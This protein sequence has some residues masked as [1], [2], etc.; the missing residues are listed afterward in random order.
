MWPFLSC[1]LPLVTGV[2]ISYTHSLNLYFVYILIFRH[3]VR[4]TFN[5][6]STLLAET[7][8]MAR[9]RASLAEVLAAEMVARLDVMAKDVTFLSRKVLLSL[10]CWFTYHSKLLVHYF[11]KQHVFIYYSNKHHLC[12]YFISVIYHVYVTW[13]VWERRERGG[14][15][16]ERER[17][18]S[19]TDRQK[20]RAEVEEC[21]YYFYC[22]SFII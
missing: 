5:L 3:E 2:L 21:I 4:S 7:R 12:L 1:D 13:C 14:E 19:T 8:R 16:R 9:D 6:W 10:V 17:E 20:R 15:D 18:R 11:H 22:C